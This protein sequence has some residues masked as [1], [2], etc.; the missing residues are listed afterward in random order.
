VLGRSGDEG[1]GLGSG[2]GKNIK[3]KKSNL[4]T[5][6]KSISLLHLAL[7]ILFL[8]CTANS[9]LRDS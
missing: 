6:N 9:K 8:E 3:L 5:P 2:I 4:I 7:A 1:L